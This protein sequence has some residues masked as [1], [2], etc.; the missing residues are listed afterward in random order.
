M[1]T[2]PESLGFQS[3]LS[4]L[5]GRRKQSPIGL[6]IIQ[7]RVRIKYLPHTILGHYCRIAQPHKIFYFHFSVLFLGTEIYFSKCYFNVYEI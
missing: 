4:C 6:P 2:N 7:C 1:I 3:K 5:H